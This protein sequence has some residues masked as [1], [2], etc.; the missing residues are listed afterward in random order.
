[1]LSMLSST[2]AKI[3]DNSSYWT[4]LVYSLKSFTGKAILVVEH[5]TPDVNTRRLRVFKFCKVYWLELNGLITNE[6][7][8]YPHEI[9]T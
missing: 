6:L 4:P 2:P 9:I 3:G 5:L 1:M 7:K 8:V